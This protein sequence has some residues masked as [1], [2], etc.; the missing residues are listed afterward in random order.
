MG[1][2]IAL[3]ILHLLRVCPDLSEK[4]YQIKLHTTQTQPN[5]LAYYSVRLF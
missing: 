2:A 1:F 3:P 5:T 4:R